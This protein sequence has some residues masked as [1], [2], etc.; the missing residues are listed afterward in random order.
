MTDQIYASIMVAL[1]RDK[2]SAE[3]HFQ[4][5]SNKAYWQEVI[6]EIDTAIQYVKDT[7]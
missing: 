6:Q 5:S 1:K 7:L 3:E 2:R 4:S